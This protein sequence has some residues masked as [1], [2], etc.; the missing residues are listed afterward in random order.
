MKTLVR[1]I[2]FTGA[3]AVGANGLF[4]AQASN[5]WMEQWFKAKYGRNT[6]MEEARQRAERANT[7]FREESVSTRQG[8]TWF[9]DWYK[10]KYGRPSPTEEARLKAERTSTAFREEPASP[11]TRPANTWFEGWYKAKYG[12]TAPGAERK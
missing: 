9:E 3:L 11:T 12:R 4:A 2:L 5:V 6:P 7:A 10:A 8:N 1:S